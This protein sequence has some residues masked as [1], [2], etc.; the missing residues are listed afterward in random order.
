MKGSKK[1]QAITLNGLYAATLLLI[2]VGIAIGIGIFILNATADAT[3]TTP[4]T[5]VNESRLAS[6]IDDANGVTLTGGSVCGSHDFVINTVI[7]GSN[8]THVIDAP[9]YTV[10]S[11]SGRFSNLTGDGMNEGA[12]LGW[13]I[14]YSYIGSSS[15][16]STSSCRALITTSEGVGGFASWI[17]VIVVVLAA[18]IV[19]GIVINSFTKNGKSAV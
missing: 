3:S 6:N 9:N 1:A 2:T 19:L 14:T 11:S 10:D 4:Y 7:N 18:A 17:A 8:L 12:T 13:N 5:I 15:N 16:D